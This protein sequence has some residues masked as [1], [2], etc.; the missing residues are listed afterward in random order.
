MK[1]RPIQLSLDVLE[2]LGSADT[3]RSLTCALMSVPKHTAWG[4]RG[5]DSPAYAPRKD[6]RPAS[7][8]RK[9]R[10]EN[11]GGQTQT[12]HREW[13]GQSLVTQCKVMAQQ[14]VR[15]EGL[16]VSIPTALHLQHLL[17]T[18]CSPSPLAPILDLI[19]EFLYLVGMGLVPG[20]S[21]PA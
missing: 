9:S 17:V 10:H 4:E 11:T 8:L 6:S 16:L 20:H 2:A 14:C 3:G 15:N 19:L 5:Q 12:L 13:A 1:W 7:P 21:C 18:N